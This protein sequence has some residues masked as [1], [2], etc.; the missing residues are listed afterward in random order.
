MKLACVCLRHVSESLQVNTRICING[1]YFNDSHQNTTTGS[2]FSWGGILRL[3]P[4]SPGSNI[5]Y[6]APCYT[7]NATEPTEERTTIHVLQ[8]Y[9]RP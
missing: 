8:I 7:S 6:V 9:L 4:G 5:I 3:L 1:M 2:D